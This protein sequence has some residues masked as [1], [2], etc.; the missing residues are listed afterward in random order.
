MPL[1][2]QPFD[3]ARTDAVKDFNRR[4]GAAGSRWQFPESPVPSWLAPAEGSPVFQEFFV[5]AEADAVRGAYALQ[6]RPA[7]INGAE[8]AIGAWYLPISEG[9][10]DSKYALVA[11]QLVRDATRREPLSFGLG[12]DGVD[13]QLSKLVA[14]LHHERRVVPFFVCIEQGGRFAREARHVRRRPAL[15]R[16]LD[17][18]A[19]TGIAWLGAEL[20]KLVLRRGPG[21]GDASVETVPQFGAWADEVWERCRGSYSFVEHRDA[22]T[23]ARIYPAGR[24]RLDRLRISRAGQSIGWAVLQRAQMKRDRMYGSLHVGRITDCLAA[25]ED[26]GIVISAATNCLVAHGVEVMLTNQFH[27]AWCVA[28]R[29]NA[30]LSVPSNFVFAPTARLAERIRAIDPGMRRVHL[31]RGDG[32]GAWGQIREGLWKDDACSV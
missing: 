17:L 26:A 13:S 21:L 16:A 29:R 18:A 12:M 27:P 6:H 23:L 2:I 15:R 4:M 32:D 1:S 30:F 5:A 14:I 9:T 19:A 31:N 10:I 24:P 8:Q 28:L 11:A 3:A 20:L 7:V 22:A 25:P